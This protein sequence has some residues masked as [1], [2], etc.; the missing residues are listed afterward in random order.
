MA[1]FNSSLPIRTQSNGDVVVEIADGTIPSQKLAVDASGRITTLMDDGSGN[2]ITSQA[3]G[4]QRALDVGIDVAGVQVDPRQIRA[5]TSADVITANQGAANA[6]PWNQNIAQIA[7]AVPSAT[8]ALP[9]QIATAGAFVSSS[10][11]LPVSIASASPGVAIQDYHTSV[12]LAATASVTFTYT[13]VAA[14]TFSLE[15]VFASASGKIKVAVT[16]GA[17]TIFT[18]FNSTANPNVDITV[19]SPP[20]IAAAGTVTVTITNDDLQSFDVYATIEGNQN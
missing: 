17:T 14:H 12:A 20:T 18:A 10:N 6:V 1:D 8:N 7:G 3:N 16:N 19:V 9:S 2:A 13:V 15:R 5:L 11:P 4:I